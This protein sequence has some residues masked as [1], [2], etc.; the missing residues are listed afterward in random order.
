MGIKYR[1]K[2]YSAVVCL[3][4]IGELVGYIGRIM[5]HSNPWNNSG[6]IIQILL[7][8]VSPSLLAA[9]LYL[10]I[11]H[12]VLHFGPQ[13]SRLRPKLYTL[14]FVTCDAAGF[15]TQCVGGG[16]QASAS[17]D[18]DG[19]TMRDVGSDIMITGISFQAATMAVCALL[20]LDFARTLYKHRDERR[21]PPGD[22]TSTNPQ[23]FRFYL[24]CT[25]TAF[26]TILIR[27]IYRYV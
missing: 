10:T 3:G 25:I 11:K 4:C 5:M 9:G 19:K 12:L 23:A 13:Y 14:L 15:L 26:V 24:G 7:L 27:C 22:T 2:L 17:N 16:I 1:V 18:A 20:A 21:K 6:F 8:I